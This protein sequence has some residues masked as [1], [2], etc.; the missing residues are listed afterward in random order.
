[1]PSKAISYHE[2][3]RTLTGGMTNTCERDKAVQHAGDNYP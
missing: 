1:M 3:R 2:G